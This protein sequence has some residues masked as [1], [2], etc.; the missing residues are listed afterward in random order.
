MDLALEFERTILAHRLLDQG[1]RVLLAVSGGLDSVV[2]MDVF[3]GIRASLQ[4]QLHVVH[5]HHGLRGEEANRDADF[6]QSLARRYQVQFTLKKVD[7]KELASRRRLSLEEAARI[8]RYEAFEE[9]L[10]E[11]GFIKVATAHSASDQTETVLD[12]F[13]RGSGIRGLGGISRTRAPYIRPFLDFTRQ[14]LHNHA[15]QQNLQY[16]EDSSNSDVR[17]KRNRIRHQLIPL[18]EGSFNP[19]LTRT[20]NRSAAILRET[21]LFLND[22][23]SN[24]FKALVFLDNKNEIILDHDRFINYFDIVKKYIIFIACDF[25][26]IDRNYLTFEK[27]ERILKL[28]HHR[29]IGKRVLINK[30]CELLVDHDGIVIRKGGRNRKAE[31][32]DLHKEDS[33]VFDGYEFRWSII[34]RSAEVNFTTNTTVELFDFDAVGSKLQLRNF[35]PGDRFVPLNFNGRK[36]IADYF[37]DRKVPH[38]LRDAIPILESGEDIVWVCGYC[39]DDRF[40]VT[41]STNRLLKMEMLR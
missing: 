19:N 40:K 10:E 8:L 25:L 12:R 31:R 16:R 23:A 21:E 34:E 15:V 38:R 13:L 29:R 33:F 28:I 35:R 1:D 2:L 11:T 17:F 3:Q 39:I 36:K 14:E 20:V 26:R 32:L 5:V 4:L 7:T 18:L 24:A 22:F 30:E 27:L 41:K 6:V 9:A 37:S